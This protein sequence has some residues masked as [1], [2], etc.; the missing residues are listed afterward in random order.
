MALDHPERRVD[1]ADDGFFELTSFSASWGETSAASSIS[2]G[3]DLIRG[4]SDD[5][6]Q[7]PMGQV[8]ENVSWFRRADNN[9]FIIDGTII[10]RN[11]F[12]RSIATGLPPGHS[13]AANGNRAVAE[14]LGVAD[15]Q[16]VMYGRLTSELRYL[17]LTADDVNMVK[18]A[19]TGEDQLAGTADDYSVQLQ[20][21]A[22]CAEPHELKVSFAAL[23]EGVLGECQMPLVDFAFPQPN[24]LLARHY[25]LV[26]PAAGQALNIVLTTE[27]SWEF[28]SAT[29]LFTDGFEIG[30][31]SRWA[32]VVP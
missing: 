11:A 1:L 9:P 19:R 16:A 30:N 13:W 18:M 21:V 8:A 6:Q 24:P 15:S 22:S 23:D 25:K 14:L 31:T 28:G 10:D 12:A 27:V 26:T 29:A 3:P 32:E 4:S 20:V 17:G 2:A 5:T 7:A